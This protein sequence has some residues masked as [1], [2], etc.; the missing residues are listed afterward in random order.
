MQ[1]YDKETCFDS[2]WLHGVINCLYDAGLKN[3][4]LLFLEN[5]NAQVAVKNSS[6]IS[7]RKNIRNI[8]MQ[9]S[10]WGSLCCVILIDKLGKH[11]YNHHELTYL[12][13]GLIDVPSL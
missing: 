10:V 9:G 3:D 2:L 1:V 6:R 5:C 4:K 11:M 12:H 8:I 13:K 7:E